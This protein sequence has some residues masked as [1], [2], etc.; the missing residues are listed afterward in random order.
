MHKYDLW[1]ISKSCISYGTNQMENQNQLHLENTH[2]CLFI[3]Y[4]TLFFFELSVTD[5]AAYVRYHLPLSLLWFWFMTK[6]IE[7]N[8]IY[9]LTHDCIT[10][11]QVAMVLTGSPTLGAQATSLTQSLCASSFSS[12]THWPSSSL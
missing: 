10:W 9:H 3:V 11:E 8:T 5:C 7:K 4:Y 12:S 6:L 2:F 1:L